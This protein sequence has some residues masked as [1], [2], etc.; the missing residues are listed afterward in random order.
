MQKLQIGGIAL[1]VLVS[2]AGCGS[3]DD[4][5]PQQAQAM[6]EG[7]SKGVDDSKIT[8]EQREHMKQFM[9]GGA[10]GAASS[11]TKGTK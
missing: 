11:P 10:A 3:G 6:K 4:V 8:P 9:G 2:L 5:S 7:F 1:L